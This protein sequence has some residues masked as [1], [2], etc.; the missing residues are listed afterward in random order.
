MLVVFP[1]FQSACHGSRT[2]TRARRRRQALHLRL[3]TFKQPPRAAAATSTASASIQPHQQQPTTL[4]FA[5][6][7]QQPSQRLRT[8][9]GHRETRNQRHPRPTTTPQ[10][11]VNALELPLP[12]TSCCCVPAASLLLP[13]LHN[14]SVT[15]WAPAQAPTLHHPTHPRR[16]HHLHVLVDA[17]LDDEPLQLPPNAAAIISASTHHRVMKFAV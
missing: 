6:T 16:R 3:T 5:S 7:H 14:N 11:L 9:T 17:L 10:R 4:Q 15:Q 12:P 1:A 13:S 8:A 2:S